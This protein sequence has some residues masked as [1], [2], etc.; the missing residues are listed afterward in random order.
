MLQL[1]EAGFD[2][3]DVHD[4]LLVELPADG[5]AVDGHGD[6]VALLGLLLDILADA[7]APDPPQVPPVGTDEV[8]PGRILPAS[9]RTP[10]MAGL[11]ARKTQFGST[12]NLAGKENMD[13][14]SVS[15][16]FLQS[17]THS[18]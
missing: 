16:C 11:L 9:T 3:V 4:A 14:L 6:L 2:E 8:L 5:D 1:L 10:T 13:L 17:S 7:D 18:M 12:M 15:F